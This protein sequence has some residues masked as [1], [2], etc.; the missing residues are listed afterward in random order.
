MVSDPFASPPLLR[1][2][3]IRLS[4]ADRERIRTVAGRAGMPSS[5]W[6]RHAARLA[7]R[8]P[9]TPTPA[10]IAKQL[11]ELRGGMGKIGSLINQ[12]AAAANAGNALSPD[13]LKSA[14][15]DLATLRDKITTT[16]A[17]IKP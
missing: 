9:G 13:A 16:I 11:T 15:D 10:E 3:Q 4:D 8:A 7:W 1:T 5:V 2:L 17:T 14:L 12:I 6:L